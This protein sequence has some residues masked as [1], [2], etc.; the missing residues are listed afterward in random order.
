MMPNMDPATM[1]KMLSRMG[2]KTDDINALRVVIECSDKEIVIDKP[3]VTQIS[4]QGMLSFQIAGDVHERFK[5]VGVDITDE[6]VE[7]VMEQT[8]VANKELVKQAIADSNGDIA[9]AIIKLKKEK[10]DRE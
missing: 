2:I 7:L 1:K 5:K 9:Q 8:G 3:Q 10:E 4:A 6:D